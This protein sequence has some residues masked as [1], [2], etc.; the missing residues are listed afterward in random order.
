M[1]KVFLSSVA[2][3]LE[4]YRD[5]VYK[6][7]EG[8]D[9]YHCIRM[10]NFGARDSRSDTVCGDKVLECDIFVGILGH[11][12]GS[13]NPDTNKSYCELEYDVAVAGNLKRLFFLASDDFPTLG[14]LIGAEENKKRQRE[15]RNRIENDRHV[16]YF[17]AS[18]QL[19]TLV[20]QAIENCKNALASRIALGVQAQP[21]KT[22]LLFPF[23][24]SQSGF[25][26]GI[27]ISN[28]SLDPLGTTPRGG[29]VKFHFYGPSATILVE[30]SVIPPGQV[31][32]TLV[33][34]TLSNI[35]GGFQGYLIAECLFSPVRGY[36]FIS[37]LGAR[38]LATSYFAE[39]IKTDLA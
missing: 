21:S 16:A 20:L 32:T 6:A 10:E 15:F 13:V 39:E 19:G 35:L 9:G 31:F 3:G 30:T 4:A 18:D 17:K 11:E 12:Y 23:V 8:L 14:H 1:T 29:R 28:I 27:T 22:W 38:N 25:D 34:T 2:A 33:S 5:A 24:T 7:I 37:D 36:A 26:T